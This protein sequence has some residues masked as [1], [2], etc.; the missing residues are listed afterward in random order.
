[1]FRLS[2]SSENLAMSLGYLTKPISLRA[3]GASWVGLKH[4]IACF[5]KM[6]HNLY[7]ASFV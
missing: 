5:A 6:Y 4:R 3:F 2:S 1:M 7:H